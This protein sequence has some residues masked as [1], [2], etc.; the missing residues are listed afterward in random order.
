MQP[1]KAAF[2][3]LLSSLH[4]FVALEGTVWD[5]RK[6]ALLLRLSLALVV[7]SCAS[8]SSIRHTHWM[9]LP[10]RWI[11]LWRRL[12]VLVEGPP[13]RSPEA[14]EVFHTHG[15]TVFRGENLFSG[16]MSFCAKERVSG[17]AECRPTSGS[18]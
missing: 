11:D 5:R 17:Q 9:R 14:D 1:A 10:S 7:G 2:L 18:A 4:S 8:D 15:R 6:G 13:L 16:R 12:T 3:G